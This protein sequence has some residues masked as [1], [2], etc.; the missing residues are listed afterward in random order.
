MAK[1]QWLTPHQKGIVRRYYDNKDNVALQTLSEIVS[2]LYLC[3]DPKQAE[4]LWKKAQTALV[5]AGVRQEKAA[6]TVAARDLKALAA[7]IQE[8]F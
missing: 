4:R 5:N 1:H 8:V 3:T 2:D 6:S 7:L